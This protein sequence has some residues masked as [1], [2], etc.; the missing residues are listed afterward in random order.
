MTAPAAASLDDIDRRL[1]VA[2]GLRA[3]VVPA[4]TT[5]VAARLR[6]SHPGSVS[7]A[8]PSDARTLVDAVRRARA[9]TV[10]IDGL[11]GFEAGDWEQLDKQRGSFQRGPLMV[12]ILSARSAERLARHAPHLAS[13]I[14]PMLRLV[15]ERGNAPLPWLEEQVGN[16]FSRFTAGDEEAAMSAFHASSPK[17]PE[18]LGRTVG[19]LLDAAVVLQ[20]VFLWGEHRSRDAEESR[21]EARLDAMLRAGWSPSR[22]WAPGLPAVDLSAPVGMK[23]VN[24]GAAYACEAAERR[25]LGATRNTA[26]R[27]AVIALMFD[28]LATRWRRETGGLSVVRQRYQHPA[29]GQILS[30]GMEVVPE[31]LRRLEHQ[32]D[33]WHTALAQLTGENPIASGEKVTVS[34]TCARWVAWGRRQ[35]LVR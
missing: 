27:A 9:A 15:E 21:V 30:M 19:R 6:R 10:L 16:L 12:F 23:I 20:A 24:D 14:S 18:L 28:A 34:Q 7:I 3:V 29:M 26:A 13:L 33:H 2:A 8:A 31:I 5:P 25:H 35:G 1:T 4:A 32:P 17:S 22:L 11:D